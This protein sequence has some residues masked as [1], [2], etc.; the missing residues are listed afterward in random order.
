MAINFQ[1]FK[2]TLR[3]I[4]AFELPSSNDRSDLVTRIL[5]ARSHM[6]VRSA[7]GRVYLNQRVSFGYGTLHVIMMMNCD[8]GH[9]SLLL[10]STRR[11]L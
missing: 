4:A 11:T 6:N 10:V 1:A 9:T 2:W 3:R 7:E 5:S 8:L